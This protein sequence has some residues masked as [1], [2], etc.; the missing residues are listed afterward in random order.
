M[1]PSIHVDA[2][3]LSPVRK[4]LE[5]AKTLEREG[6]RIVHFEIGEPD[7]D[8]PLQ[9]KEATIEA[10][11][12]NH[13][14]YG[15]NRGIPELRRSISAILGDE[16]GL[17]YDPDEEII[18]TVGAAEAL[19]AAVGGYIGNGD[20][21]I[22]FTPAF[23]NYKNLIALFGGTCVT[24]PLEESESFQINPEVVR[25]HITQK[26]KMLVINNPHNPTGT[27]F[28]EQSLR[29]LS[30]IAKKHDLL[31][32]S[33]E[34][35]QKIVYDGK[36]C[37]SIGSIEGM[38]ERTITINGFSKSH[39][40][41]GW[42]MGYLAA[43]REL[44]M[45]LLKIHQYLTTCAPTFIQE[46]LAI[47]L[48]DPRCEQAVQHMVQVF[49][50]R[51]KLLVKGLAEIPNLRFIVPMGAFYLFLNV[52]STGLSG[53]DFASRLLEEKGVAVVPGEGFD[54]HFA[55]YVRISYATSEHEIMKGLQLIKDFISA[56]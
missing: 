47:G 50:S 35:Y 8:T 15:P 3:T 41:T 53:T 56:L 20:E 17:V 22:V 21:V 9:I 14:H 7:F 39:A 2:M 52:T 51:R 44:I 24:I 31:V 46:G 37:F 28:N 55:N 43:P 10:I 54:H 45:P 49:A 25:N 38:K 18:V 33:D 40:M 16:H 19:L 29:E 26:T 11:R 42:R 6:R 27:V 1:K 4:V 23:M 13:T 48:Q 5:R 32:I 30:S 12:G 36:R 34:I